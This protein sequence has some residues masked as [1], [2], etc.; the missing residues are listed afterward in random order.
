L[1]SALTEGGAEGKEKL[2][3]ILGKKTA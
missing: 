2:G 1:E 3:G